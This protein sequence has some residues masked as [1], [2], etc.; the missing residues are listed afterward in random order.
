ML[1]IGFL[2]DVAWGLA[3]FRKHEMCGHCGADRNIDG[4]LA[5]TNLHFDAGWRATEDRTRLQFLEACEASTHP[6]RSSIYWNAW[7]CRIDI[8]HCLDHR[9]VAGI[10]AGSCLLDIVRNC[11]QLGPNQAVRLAWINEKLKT[12]NSEHVVSSK[13]DKLEMKNLQFGGGRSMG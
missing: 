4:P 9:G 10:V 6:L 11:T 2:Q 1:M 5:F 12:W 13:I 3:D 7:F 8:M